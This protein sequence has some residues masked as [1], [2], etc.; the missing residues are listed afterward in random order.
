MIF[1]LKSWSNV[2][3]RACAWK[4]KSRQ[5][6]IESLPVVY[7]EPLS[8]SEEKIH[9]LSISELV[10][11]CRSGLISPSEIMSTYGK[12]A[13]SAQKA[14]NCVSDI[15][16]LEALAI[17]SVANW[18]RGVDSDSTNTADTGQDRPLLGV[19]ISIKDTVDIQG[20]DT[21]IGFSR[22]VGK[23]AKSS[24]AIVNLLQDA[25][26][27]IHAKTTVPTALLAIETNSDVFG[28]TSNPYNHAYTCGGS[29]GGGAALVASGG[30]K[31]EI[32]TDI[33]GSVRIPAHFCGIWSLKGS[34]GRFPRWG[35]AAPTDGLEGIEIIA[36]PMAGNLNDLAEFWERVIRCKP[37]VYDH[38]CIPLPW[39]AL[40]LREDGRRLK[41]GIIWED[42]TIP[43]APACRRALSLVISALRKQGHEV[44]NFEPPDIVGCLLLGYQLLFSDG[45]QQ[46]L[47]LLSPSER[48]GTPAKSVIDLLRLPRFFKRLLSFSTRKTDPLAT[49][50]AQILHKKTVVEEREL[51]VARDRYR[52]KWHEKWTEEGLD[53]VLTVPHALPAFEHGAS[54]KA[55]L[56][57][58]GYNFIFS[59]LDYTAGVLPVTVVDRVAD[60]L[61]QGF[62]SSR[63]YTSMN[64]ASQGAYSVYDAKKMHGLP[65]GVQIVGKRLEE[66]KVLEGMKIIEAA[67][68]EQGTVFS[69]KP[70][71]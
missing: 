71:L 23:P 48:L 15:M 50:F 61:P 64:G 32:G 62:F 3:Q 13:L 58:A 63:Q 1:T 7:S 25:G 66:E 55:T 6:Q 41:W 16:F 30:S 69:G 34:A 36:S 24:A 53:L 21:T 42:G 51:V 44:V 5:Q 26:A 19:P 59:V 52:A 60:A 17:P 31:I 39:R 9:A 43:P 22:N 46:I 2:H 28:H 14:T 47:N 4:E 56:V 40:N 27:L 35:S 11:Q 37:W 10:Y 33:G 45:G 68:R 12:K 67:L 57:S 38:T 29:T 65:V 8:S 49:A 18:S 20:H 70:A 54:A